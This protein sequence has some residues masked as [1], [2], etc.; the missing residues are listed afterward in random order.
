MINLLRK[1]LILKFERCKNVAYL[2]LN[3]L[4]L[5]IDITIYFLRKQNER[6]LHLLSLSH[7]ENNVLKV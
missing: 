1:P 4:H 3:D 2:I 5:D 6:L 7:K